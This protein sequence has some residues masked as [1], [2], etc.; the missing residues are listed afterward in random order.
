M[1]YFFTISVRDDNEPVVVLNY[2]TALEAVN[3]YNR[4]VDYGMAKETRSVVFYEPNGTLHT[5]LF[6][7]SIVAQKVPALVK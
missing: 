1:N 7:T 5:K 6:H 4:F 2:T 3:A